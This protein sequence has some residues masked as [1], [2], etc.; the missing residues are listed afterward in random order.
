MERLKSRFGLKKRIIIAAAGPL[1]LSM[2]GCESTRVAATP[3]MGGVPVQMPSLIATDGV[4]TSMLIA[5]THPLQRGS[6]TGFAS[7]E[8]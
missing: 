2:V 4:G 7:A 3:N 6:E 8:N 1:A 5:G